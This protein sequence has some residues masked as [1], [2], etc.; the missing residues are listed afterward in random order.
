[1][2]KKS[3]EKIKKWQAQRDNEIILKNESQESPFTS[4]CKKA[5]LFGTFL[6]L[7]TPL[8]LS[9]NFFFPF[10]GPKSL[11]FMGLVQL[12]SLI[13]LFLI[14]IDKRYRPQSNPLLIALTLFIIVSTISSLLGEN[15]S[16]SFWS[17]YERMA[18]LLMLFHLLVFFVIISSVFKEQMEWFK[19]FVISVFVALVVSIISLLM[20]VD[21]S[22]IGQLGTIS[23][24]GAT[25]GNSS[26]MG[27]YLLFNIFFAIYLI[28]KT[29]N[30]L[31]KIFL[32]GSFLIIFL[33]LIL[34]GARAATL[35]FFGGLILLFLFWLILSKRGGLRFIGFVLLMILIMGASYFTYLT[36]QQGSFVR[37]ELMEMGFGA[38]L[39]VWQGALQGWLE[40]P[41]L[42]W[43]LESFQLVFN[44][45]FNPA[46]FLP[47]Y[48]R[49]IRFDRA[50]NIIVDTLV[51]TGI[52]GL[53]TY[54]GI[55]ITALYLLFKTYLKQ[56]A[57]F[58]TAG[59]FSS[60]LVAHLVQNL[61]VFDMVSS[62]MI[63]FL[64]LGFVESITSRKREVFQ[65]KIGSLSPLVAVI[66]FV[67][68]GFSFFYFIIQPLVTANNVIQTFAGGQLGS[69]ERTLLYQK[70]LTTSSPLGREQIRIVFADEVTNFLRTKEGVKAAQEKPEV[71]RLKFD[72]LSQELRKNIKA[73]SL[74]F[75]SYFALGNLYLAWAQI[76]PEKLVS[77]EEAIR[78]AIE[79]SPKHPRPYWLLAQ[80]KLYQGDAEA[81]IALAQEVVKIEPR[82]DQ[83]HFILV[84]IAIISGNIDFAKERAR[85][86]IKIN[87]TWRQRFEQLLG[88][89][90]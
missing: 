40:R 20:K 88:E 50:H 9:E 73:S 49:E 12:I 86:A 80:V 81:A 10:V 78:R 89:K 31:L 13:Y 69:H 23:Q 70:T 44:Q 42:G 53:L 85:E 48:G 38:R 82:I 67:F 24:A 61:T 4:I 59:L 7:F 54:L 65:E 52:V 77:A 74:D 90:I 32:G 16:L 55:F 11:Y 17:N 68:F 34:S 66:V 64:T 43:G 29:R 39:L 62:Y 27:T 47:Q 19:I 51:T 3:R 26:F 33:A 45:H 21:I 46:L 72:F 35:S 18:G 14:S 63:F 15:F 1:M 30:N 87:P 5:I 76:S 75:E 79:I 37:Q 6:I 41:W 58:L 60:L 8:I 83:G 2:G 56:R 57:N 36:F 25:L 84:E 71:F 22:L 28:F